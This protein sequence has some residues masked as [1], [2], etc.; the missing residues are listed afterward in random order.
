[1]QTEKE[2]I[3]DTDFHDSDNNKPFIGIGFEMIELIKDWD[4]PHF[5]Y[6]PGHCKP[7]I[8]WAEILHISISEFI[9][10]L[11]TKKYMLWFK[12]GEVKT[13]SSI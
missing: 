7:A 3:V 2:A 12:V 6:H 1:M 13:P 8:E 11:N 10:N 5:K 9:A 4:H